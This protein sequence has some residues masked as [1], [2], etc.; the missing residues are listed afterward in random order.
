MPY[1][2]VWPSW[3]RFQAVPRKYACECLLEYKTCSSSRQVNHS[4]LQSFH[5]SSETS[6]AYHSFSNI[7]YARIKT[8]TQNLHLKNMHL[9]AYVATHSMLHYSFSSP[10]FKQDAC[11]VHCLSLCRR[12]LSFALTSAPCLQCV[13]SDLK[14]MCQKFKS[15]NP[16]NKR[17]KSRF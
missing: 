16:Q 7:L 9:C 13:V 6:L 11:Y 2:C 17:S 1:L 5:C 14:E 10:K 8:H 15:T 4:L 3:F 12:S